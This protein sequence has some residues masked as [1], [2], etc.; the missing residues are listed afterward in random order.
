MTNWILGSA[1]PRRMDLLRL[2]GHPFTVQTAD[3][4]EPVLYP[5]DPAE[6]AL[7]LANRKHDALLQGR[8]HSHTKVG[9]NKGTTNTT[10]NTTTKTTTKTKAKPTSKT[11]SANTF[12]ITADTMVFADGII[13]NKPIDPPDAHRM[14]Q[15]LSGRMHEVVTAV[16]LSIS[17][18]QGTISKKE[19]FTETT[20]V[21]FHELSDEEIHEYV[22]SGSPMDKAGAYGIQD[23]RGA[24]FV[25]RIEGDYYNVVGFPLQAFYQILKQSFTEEY[26]QCFFTV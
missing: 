4:E 26:R 2:T 16:V 24:F 17:D 1:S 5:G 9:D 10:T 8:K 14:L 19:A 23:D 18:S 22:A 6:S 21:Y 15:F 13:L 7:A 12:L 3:V 25:R 11:T 20:R